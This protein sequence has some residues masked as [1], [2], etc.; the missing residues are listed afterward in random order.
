MKATRHTINQF[1]VIVHNDE[2][3]GFWVQ[4]PSFDGCYSQGKTIDQ[5]LVNIREAIELC[6]Q[7]IP[8]K[9]QTRLARQGVSLHLVNV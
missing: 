3:G 7:D 9:Q 6:L 5:A 4:C 8:K 2:S 1:P